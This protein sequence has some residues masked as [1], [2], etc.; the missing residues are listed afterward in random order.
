M[1]RSIRIIALFAG[2]ALVAQQASAQESKAAKSTREKLKQ[3]IDEF[4]AKE[5]GM[6]AFFE[7]VNREI[8]KSINFKIDVSAG[9]N[10]TKV[11][12]KGKK[13]TV[14][15]LLN[16]LSDKYEF[17]WVVISNPD[18]NKIDGWVIIRR[19]E[20][21]KERGYE[22]GKEPKKTS[23]GTP[24]SSEF[25]LVS[26]VQAEDVKKDL[27]ALNG[28]WLGAR[29]EDHQHILSFKERQN[30][31][32]WQVKNFLKGKDAV[33]NLDTKTFE[34]RLDPSVMPKQ[35][36]LKNEKEPDRL[37]IY[38]IKGDTLRIAIGTAKDRP[39]SLDDGNALSFSL[40]KQ[41]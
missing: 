8:Q 39:K 15:K 34:F 5:V 17:G 14:E 2:L 7:D 13:I 4:E 32:V 11:S 19:S 16:D 33:Q 6:K 12:Y 31:V 18:N 26:V 28:R 41:K 9:T 24:R 23:S 29:V 35:I 40:K 10:N 36:T 3:V 38:D 25:S 37:G 27:A 22:A 20:K 1:F 30:M 21:G